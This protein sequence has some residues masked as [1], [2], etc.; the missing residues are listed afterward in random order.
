MNRIKIVLATLGLIIILIIYSYLNSITVNFPPIRNSDFK[1]EDCCFNEIIKSDISSCNQRLEI[2][3]LAEDVDCFQAFMFT[4]MNISW[5]LENKHNITKKCTFNGTYAKCP[6][7]CNKCTFI[8]MKT[9]LG[10]TGNQMFQVASLLG[11]AKKRGFIPIIPSTIPINKWFDLPTLSEVSKPIYQSEVHEKGF[12]KYL[13]EIEDLDENKNW[14]IAGYLQS[15][16]YFD[17]SNDIIH[18]LFDMKFEKQMRAKDILRSFSP[19][20]RLT[21]KILLKFESYRIYFK[22]YQ[23]LMLFLIFSDDEI[24]CIHVRRGDLLK[25]KNIKLGYNPIDYSPFK[26]AIDDF[27]L[28]MS[29]NNV[30]ITSGTFGWWGAY[31][32]GG[33]VV[34]HNGYPAKGSWLDQR[35]KRGDYYLTTWTGLGDKK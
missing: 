16:R 31:L 26:E 10:R 21:L 20:F 7:I 30:V 28:M 18:K 23:Y 14:T 9:V 33:T 1:H 15:F 32:S 17:S 22:T 6:W 4:K 24:V 5:K 34:Y 2:H 35:I 3:S 13:N 12:G 19:S 29:C 11:I 27:A 8:T 25:G